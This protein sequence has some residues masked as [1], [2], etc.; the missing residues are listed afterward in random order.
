MFESEFLTSTEDSKDVYRKLI[1]R[2]PEIV[3]ESFPNHPYCGKNL[4]ALAEAVGTIQR[5]FGKGCGNLRIADN[6]S[7]TVHI[8]TTQKAA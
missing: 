2:A 5:P 7:G 1:A 4:A 8:R 6:S 3:C